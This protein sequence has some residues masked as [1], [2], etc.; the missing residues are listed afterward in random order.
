MMHTL[1]AKAGGGNPLDTLFSH[2]LDHDLTGFLGELPLISTKHQLMIVTATI[3]CI[4]V[5]VGTFRRAV[6]VPTGFRNAMEAIV[7]FLRNSVIHEY[8]HDEKHRRIFTPYF[9]TVFFFILTMNLLGM[10][11]KGASAT[12]NIA[13]T[14]TL[15]LCGFVLLLTSGMIAQ[16]PGAFWKSLVPSGVPGWLYFPLFVLEVIGLVS[17]HFALT[18]RLGANMTAGHVLLG[19]LIAFCVVAP[20]T[21]IG[22]VVIASSLAAS[23]AVGVLEL[24]VAFLQA[25]I[26]TFL[27]A[28][29]VG[30]ALH[31]DH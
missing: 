9:L 30:A 20:A 11:P 19:A 8:I 7:Q 23:V 14:L 28:V 17:K 3:I 26:F 2:V 4:V 25:Y 18:I 12:G 24:F 10:V 15:S 16:G 13:V 29:F 5:L 31:P 6:Q 27:S 1:F 22:P 21:L